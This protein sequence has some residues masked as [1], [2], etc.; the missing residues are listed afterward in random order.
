MIFH[1]HNLD[2]FAVNFG[3]IRQQPF[4]KLFR[5]QSIKIVNKKNNLNLKLTNMTKN[6]FGDEVICK[7]FILHDL[8]TANLS[9]D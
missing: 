1:F 9:T 5:Q 6:Q 7:F 2:I 4:K 3:P 8:K